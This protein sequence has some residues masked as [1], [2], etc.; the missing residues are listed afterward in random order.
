MPR[1]LL[2]GI[3][4]A[5]MTLLQA[6]AVAFKGTMSVPEVTAVP[7]NNQV[8]VMRVHPQRNLK[9]FRVQKA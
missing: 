8:P 4:G 1:T 9:I 6:H 5:L 3:A 2:A 7:E